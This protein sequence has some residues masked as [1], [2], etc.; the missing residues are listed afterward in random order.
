MARN[1]KD[2]AMSDT[3]IPQISIAITPMHRTEEGIWESGARSGAAFFLVELVQ[4]DGTDAEVVLECKD[5]RAAAL[6]A[7]VAAATAA[8]LGLAAGDGSD[9]IEAFDEETAAI[10]AANPTPEITMP[11]GEWRG[12]A[13]DE[14]EED[15]EDD[16]ATPQEGGK[17][18]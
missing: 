3:A 13:D 9:G 16:D 5:E 12:D 18:A 8:V 7:R 10:L 17:D 4:G 6:A 1:A 14:D 15:E 2:A 11:A